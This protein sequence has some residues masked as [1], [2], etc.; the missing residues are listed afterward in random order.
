MSDVTLTIDGQSVTVPQGTTILQ[1]ANLLRKEIPTVCYHP[2]FTPPSL[3]RVCVVEV[4]KSRVL[5]QSCSRVAEN[6]MVVKTDSPRVQLARRVLMEMLQSSVDLSDAPELQHYS[7]KYG[8]DA[9]RY[10]ENTRRREF[11]LFDDNPFYVRDYSKCIMCWRC[12]QACGEDVQWTFA[13]HRA[14]RGFG[15]HISTFEAVPIP[16]STC[17]YC[18]NCVQACP[19]GAL[20]GKRAAWLEQGFDLKQLVRVSNLER[21]EKS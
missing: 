2:H 6:G 9:N 1:A 20:K 18:G 21:R 3:C 7:D 15:S 12:V 4:E 14:A 11:P 10:G 16:E 19:T 8:A 17:V 13:I 5:V